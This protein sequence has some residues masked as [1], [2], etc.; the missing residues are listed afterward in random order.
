MIDDCDPSGSSFGGVLDGPDD[1]DWYKYVGADTLGCSVDAT[2]ALSASGSVRLCKFAQC[3]NGNEATIVCP[4][5]ATGAISPDGRPGCCS[6]TGFDMAP[7]C[8][9]FPSTDDS[10]LVYI[11]LDQP[12]GDCVSY[13]VDYHF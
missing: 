13:T 2:R 8:A 4:A 6:L 5:G 1:V 12:E 7:G 9:S 11:R 3:S 10:S